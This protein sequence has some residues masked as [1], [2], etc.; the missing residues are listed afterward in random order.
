MFLHARTIRGTRSRAV[1]F[2]VIVVFR[3]VMSVFN[4]SNLSILLARFRNFL[5]RGPVVIAEALNL[6]EAVANSRRH[7]VI[8]CGVCH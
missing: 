5:A 2:I 3:F 4:P 7:L 8:L 6:A 1:K